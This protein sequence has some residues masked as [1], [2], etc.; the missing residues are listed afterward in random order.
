ML[1][2][3]PPRGAGV[4]PWSSAQCRHDQGWRR[5]ALHAA[6]CTAELL[7]LT[8][9]S[10]QWQCQWHAQCQC[11]MQVLAPVPVPVAVQLPMAAPQLLPASRV[12]AYAAHRPS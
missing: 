12:R 10:V 11:R 6:M 8:A 3:D 9:Y 4:E 5:H 2:S 7:T 1:S